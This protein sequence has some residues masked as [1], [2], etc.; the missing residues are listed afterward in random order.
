MLFVVVTLTCQAT[1]ATADEMKLIACNLTVVFFSSRDIGSMYSVFTSSTL[2]SHSYCCCSIFNKVNSYTLS[3]FAII[4]LSSYFA[5]NALP[6]PEHSPR[7]QLSP[8][9]LVH[10][11]LF[12]SMCI[13]DERE[14]LFQP[15]FLPF[16]MVHSHSHSQ[17]HV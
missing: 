6:S 16:P 2:S 13:R 1:G 17:S 5:E 11:S 9:L 14:Y 10:C 8:R 4:R 7:R 3:L 12:H 15:Y